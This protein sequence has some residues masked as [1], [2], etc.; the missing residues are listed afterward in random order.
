MSSS[1]W[2]SAFCIPASAHVTLIFWRLTTFTQCFIKLITHSLSPAWINSILFSVWRCVSFSTITLIIS[3]YFCLFFSII[4]I[5]WILDDTLNPKLPPTFFSFV[6]GAF[7]LLWFYK[8]VW[9]FKKTFAIRVLNFINFFFLLLFFAPFPQKPIIIF[10]SLC[11]N[12][13]SFSSSI[14]FWVPIT[15]L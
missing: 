12:I 2:T 10:L 4:P 13:C 5:R 3:P 8:H 6:L 7:P 1:T 14:S 15:L 11:R 9:L